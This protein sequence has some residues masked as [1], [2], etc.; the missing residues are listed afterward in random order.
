MR[1]LVLFFLLW[2]FWVRSG[3]GM[4]LRPRRFFGLGLAFL[5]SGGM[6]RPRRGLVGCLLARCTLSA[7]GTGWTRHIMRGGR[8]LW[9]RLVA[10]V[11]SARPTR[12]IGR[13][14]HI[15][16]RSWS[17]ALRVVFRPGVIP[18]PRNIVGP[19]GSGRRLIGCSRLLGRYHAASAEFAGFRG[20]C[21]RWFAVV[22]RSAKLGI[23]GGSVFMLGLH[24]C[25]LNMLFMRKYLFVCRGLPGYSAGA[26]EAHPSF[27]VDDDRLVVNVVHNRDVHIGDGAVVGEVTTFPES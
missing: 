22:H 12:V 25:G 2:F 14:R 11:R 18:R 7:G 17:G 19:W 24:C 10:G 1:A 15:V 27:V 4:R 8:V 9:P 3:L 26:V 5:R 6:L 16:V 13:T 23:A 21:D 20:G